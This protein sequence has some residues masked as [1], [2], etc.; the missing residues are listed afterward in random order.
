VWAGPQHDPLVLVLAPFGLERPLEVREAEADGAVHRGQL[1]VVGE[2]DP[3][4][5]HEPPGIDEIEEDA[6][7][8]MIAVETA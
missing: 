5:A 6:F 7:E 8:A 4:R 1:S 2:D 3:A